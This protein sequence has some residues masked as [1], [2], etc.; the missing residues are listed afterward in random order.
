M[1]KQERKRGVVSL[2]S[3]FWGENG[4]RKSQVVGET[5]CLFLNTQKQIDQQ[6]IELPDAR[7]EQ[8]NDHFVVPT[9]RLAILLI[10]DQSVFVYSKTDK[11]FHRP[12][13][14][15]VAHSPPK[16]E[17]REKQPPF[18]FPVFPLSNYLLLPIFPHTP[19]LPFIFQEMGGTRLV[20]LLP[21]NNWDN[22][23][24]IFSA[25]VILG[26]QYLG[27]PPFSKK[28]KKHTA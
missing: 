17:M 3:L 28:I 15:Y 5:F 26:F 6:S 10:V 2:S 27:R 23:C 12:P 18:S 9:E 24:K 19:L 22:P 25:P 7:W 14:F 13:D 21:N 1:E 11:T 8:Q 16:K 20:S 4:R